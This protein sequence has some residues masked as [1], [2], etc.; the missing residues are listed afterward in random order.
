MTLLDRFR[1]QSPQHHP[2]VAVRLAYVAE[3]PLDDRDAIAAIA[4]GD[5][6]ARVRKAAVEK[7]MD[8]ATL[9]AIA[10]ADGDEGVRAAA[11]GMLRD[12]AL[13]AFEGTTEAQSLEAVDALPDAKAAMQVARAATRDAVAL[14]AMAGLTDSHAIGSIA[15]HAASEAAR[16]AAFHWLRDRGDHTE[17]MA[18]AL[19]G[20]H[21]ETAVAAVDWITE[22]RDLD[23]IAARS[24]NKYA[25]K[26]A[27]TRLHER[28][29]E[30]AADQKAAADAAREL[31]AAAAAREQAA[32]VADVEDVAPV[33][34]SVSEQN[35][36]VADVI[37]EDEPAAMVET[38]EPPGIEAATVIDEEVPDPA[39]LAEA[40]ADR[41]PADH[42]IPG[43]AGTATALAQADSPEAQ[44]RARR[45]AIGRLRHLAGRVEPLLAREDLSLKAAERALRDLRAALA[46]LPAAGADLDELVPRLKNAQ[47]ALTPRLQE[48]REATEWR[49]WANAGIQEQLCQQM[50][51]LATVEDPE[52]IAKTVR[53]LQQQ[54]RAAADVPRAQA[55]AL[56]RRFKAAHDAVWPRCEAHF[57]AEAEVR[58]ANLQRKIALCEQAE[59]LAESTNWI[60]TAD[61]IK[62]L[63]AEWKTI[64][65]VSRGR[66]KAIWDRFRSA[67]DRFFTRR[68][69]DLADRKKAW[70]ENFTKKEALCLKAEA[71][72]ESTDWE[73][74]AAEIRQLQAEWKTIGPVKKSRS[75]AVWQRFRAACDRFFTRYASR[76]DTARAERLAAREAISVEMETLAAADPSAD[77]PADLL[78]SVRGIRQRWNQEVASRGVDPDRARQ[79]EER[80]DAAVN[81]LIGRWPAAFAGTEFD[82]DT[83]RKRMESLVQ[84]VED[85]LRSL[86][87]PAAPAVDHMTPTERLAARLKEALAANTIGGKVDDDSR[88]RAAAEDVRQ[89]KNAWSRLGFVPDEARRPLTNRFNQ[90]TTRILAGPGGRD[91]QGSRDNRPAREKRRRDE[92]RP[93]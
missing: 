3:I 80:F 54:W 8:P 12:L 65:P 15:R 69:A 23:Q 14:R 38:P 62:A 1:T 26:R 75:E 61:A 47:S 76:H 72:A 56:W 29:K 46:D 16:L 7:L 59:S 22:S 40:V 63:Q 53:E 6:E 55:D 66:E 44:A 64:G 82:P 25:A 77:P 58:A 43:E 78:A 45:E 74:A 27:R 31:A 51:A 89:A 11:V 19:N 21:R 81:T 9:A 30:A 73:S 67:C 83:N 86:T 93:A 35:A 34:T 84:K 92:P 39:P 20:E 28:D 57:A 79:L 42:A 36:S 33:E 41:P 10:R 4:R 32:A 50:E 13:E 70:A 88:W 37:L 60:Q 5:Q 49:Q 52:A 85:L 2:D 68:H 90:A 87:G 91:V 18:L 17:I 48:L 24:R 71:L